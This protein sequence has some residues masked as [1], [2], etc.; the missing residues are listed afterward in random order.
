MEVLRD[1]E[2]LKRQPSLIFYLPFYSAFINVFLSRNIF[3]EV[4]VFVVVFIVIIACFS[5]YFIV[6]YDISSP[7]INSSND[8]YNTIINWQG[9]TCYVSNISFGVL[10]IS[11]HLLIKQIYVLLLW[12]WYGK[13]HRHKR[14]VTFPVQSYRTLLGRAGISA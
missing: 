3:D 5:T 6:N 2:L 13:R 12:L 1:E 11:S 4:Q 10:C 14:A 9:N 7:G 8:N